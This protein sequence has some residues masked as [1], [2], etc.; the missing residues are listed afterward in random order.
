MNKIKQNKITFT[1]ILAAIVIIFSSFTVLSL[2]V[3]F[4]YKSKV[5]LIEKNFYKNFKIYLK[6]KEKISY[7]PFPRPH[8]LVEKASL[9]FNKA[10]K[11]K[12]SINTSNLKIYISLRNIYLRSFSKFVSTEISDTNINLKITDIKE[13]RNHLYKKINKPIILNNCKIFLRNKKSEVIL[14]SPLK[15]IKYKINEK[16]KTKNLDIFGKVFGLDFKSEWKRNYLTPKNSSHSINI[17]NPNLDIKNNFEFNEVNNFKGQSD[18]TYYQDKMQHNIQ[19]ENNII[20]ISSQISKKT[21]FNINSKIQ[22]NPF[23]F[24]GQL[25]IKNKKIEDLV[26][27]LLFYLLIY[28]EK[29]LGNLNGNLKIKFDKLKNKLIKSGQIDFI[30]SEKKII[31]NKAKFKLDKIGNIETEISSFEDNG[32]IKFLFN[33]HLNIDNHIEFAK[34]FQIGSKKIKKIKNIS[35]DIIKSFRQKDFIITNI[36]LNDK[37]NLKSEQIFIVNNI[38]NLRSHIRK[39][40]D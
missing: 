32:E 23:Y 8:L 16:S 10:T 20:N 2:P 18:I 36:R 39:V 31:L 14:I 13:L 29:Y 35:F 7:K 1:L 6:S 28:N 37:R 27:T 24:D 34:T 17:Y 11:Y 25:L 38:Q 30:F 33:N 3:L 15:K 9:N 40:I 22:L 12:N 19:F 26:D 5:A 4:N 21:N